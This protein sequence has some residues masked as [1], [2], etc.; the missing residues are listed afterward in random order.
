M[1]ESWIPILSLVV[2][3]ILPLILGGKGK[4]KEDN[5]IGEL[6]SELGLDQENLVEE[7]EAV[8]EQ[9]DK[10]VSPQ[11]NAVIMKDSHVEE[12]DADENMEV[13]VGK[14]MSREEKKKLVIY[15]EVMSPKYKE[16]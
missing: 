12:P 14:G 10:Y 9:K 1:G 5:T 6:L 13:K 15:S 4:K 16:Y 11:I 3:F 7:I 2:F 8:E